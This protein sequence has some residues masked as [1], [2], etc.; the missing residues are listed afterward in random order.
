MKKLLIAFG[1][2]ALCSV[3]TPALAKHHDSVPAGAG[4]AQD[5]HPDQLGEGDYYVV[6]SPDL[7]T[8]VVQPM[9]TDDFDLLKKYDLSCRFQMKGQRPSGAKV[10][11]GT[12][13]RNLPGAI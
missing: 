13:A 8:G 2:A 11:L 5:K 7:R 1:L 4:Y 3:S 10:I 9:T 6:V 12:V